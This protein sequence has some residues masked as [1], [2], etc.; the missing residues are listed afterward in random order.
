M[1]NKKIVTVVQIDNRPEQRAKD[2]I[3]LAKH[4][5]QHKTDFLLLPEMPFNDWLANDKNVERSRWEAAV[6]NHNNQISKFEELGYPSLMST[7]PITEADGRRQNS[8]YTWTKDRGV[9]DFHS[10]WN[11]PDEDGYWEATWYDR[12]DGLFNSARVDDIILG[13]QI[14]TEMWFFEHARNYAKHKVDLLCVPRATPHASINK[15]LAGGQTA[16]VVSGAFCLSSNLYAP[17]SETVDIGGLSWITS[18]EGDILAQTDPDNP[19]VSVEID[20][21][22]AKIAKGNFPRYVHD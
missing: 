10:K 22:D 17:K 16:S 20:L 4:V 18:P 7:R 6:D 1:T 11:L 14:C 15:W 3:E 19:F 8:A 13:V 21:D 12:G 2:I 9:A 5:K